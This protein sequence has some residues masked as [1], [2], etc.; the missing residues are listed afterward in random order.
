MTRFVQIDYPQQHP[1]VVR[2]E[3]A[4]SQLRNMARQMNGHRGLAT[5]LLAAVVAAL[6][7]V[8]DRLID[9]WADGHLLAAWVALWA[10][11]FAALGLLAPPLRRV[12]RWAVAA[13]DAW[14]RAAAEQRAEERL[15]EIARK[16]ARVMAELISARGRAEGDGGTLSQG[17]AVREAEHDLLRESARRYPHYI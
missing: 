16:D 1:G 14:A 4:A 9:A 5:L 2:A 6:V 13:G 15:L 12:A 17:Q 8:A 10:V 3:A 11:A 7:V